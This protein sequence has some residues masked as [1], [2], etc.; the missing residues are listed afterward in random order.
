MVILLLAL[1]K[2]TIFR[3]QK[4]LLKDMVLLRMEFSLT[5]F[6]KQMSQFWQMNGVDENFSGK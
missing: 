4:A 1:L 2:T 5:A 6:W 3:A